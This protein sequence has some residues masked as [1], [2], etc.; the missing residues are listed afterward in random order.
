LIRY[1][2]NKNNTEFNFINNINEGIRYNL[3]NLNELNLYNN[4]S[5]KEIIINNN[6]LE[7]ILYNTLIKN[8]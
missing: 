4:F 1:K 8:N 2:N 7:N 5:N 3:E 6:I